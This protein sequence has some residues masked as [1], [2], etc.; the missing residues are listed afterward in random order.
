MSTA[1]CHRSGVL[2]QGVERIIEQVVNPKIFQVIKPK[3]DETVCSQLGIDMKEWQAENARRKAEILR[4]Q[5]AAQKAAQQAKIQAAIKEIQ[6]KQ[7]EKQQEQ[8]QLAELQQ[9]QQ[10]I[11]SG[12]ASATALPGVGHAQLVSVVCRH[13]LGK[14]TF[15]FSWIG[16]FG[17]NGIL[18]HDFGK[19]G[20]FVIMVNT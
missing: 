6:Q 17:E 19:F 7:L 15:L 9:Q 8:Q 13:N 12:S 14:P 20:N 10:A 4:Q 16:T 11:A 2:T 3:I 5:E 1:C 18:G